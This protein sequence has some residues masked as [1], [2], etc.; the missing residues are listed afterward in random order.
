MI[1]IKSEGDIVIGNVSEGDSNKIKS[2]Q[3]VIINNIDAIR[4]HAKSHGIDSS[5]VD[6]LLS[7]SK[8]T[9]LKS[10]SFMK[11]IKDNYSWVIDIIQKSII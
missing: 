4:Q 10:S 5:K 3:E 9:E 6:E 1:E 7:M 8:Q 2:Y 11:T